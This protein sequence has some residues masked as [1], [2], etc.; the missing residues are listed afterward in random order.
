MGITSKKQQD[1]P[2]DNCIRTAGYCEGCNKTH[3]AAEFETA[4]DSLR[5]EKSTGN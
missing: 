1:I 2:T 3:D 5:Q 4:Q